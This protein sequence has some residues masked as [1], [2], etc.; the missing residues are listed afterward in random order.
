[1][2]FFALVIV[3]SILVGCSATAWKDV[4]KPGPWCAPDTRARVFYRTVNS[5]GM[6]NAQDEMALVGKSGEKR[7][8]VSFWRELDEY[9]SK[10]SFI[11]KWPSFGTVNS[12]P[13]H[14][15][16]FDLCLVSM[17]P[18]V[19]VG[20]EKQD[21]KVSAFWPLSTSGYAFIGSTHLMDPIAVGTTIP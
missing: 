17:N 19:I 20:V 7:I 5:F 18:T 10:C 13:S 2:R 1:M 15:T 21:P 3:L 16:P 6:P 4:G 11:N 14:H 9:L 12:I 8:S